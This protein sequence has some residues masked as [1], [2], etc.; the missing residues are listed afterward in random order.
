MD[1]N[2]VGHNSIRNRLAHL[3]AICKM[4]HSILFSGQRGIGKATLAS[5]LA[6]RMFCSAPDTTAADIVPC[7]NCKSCKLIAA[8]NFP[9]IHYRDC[10]GL[11]VE[12]LRQL[13]QILNL[14]AFLGSHKVVILDNADEL[15]LQC[16]N[17]LLEPLEEALAD[18]FFF[19]ITANSGA[20]PIT[21]RS[22]CQTFFFQGLAA[23]DLEI[24]VQRLKGRALTQSEKD[25][26]SLADGSVAGLDRLEALSELFTKFDAKLKSI[27]SGNIPAALE[28]AKE[29]GKQKEQSADIFHVI[30]SLLRAGVQAGNRRMATALLETLRAEESH[31]RRHVN[32]T[33]LFE[34]LF[35]ELA[36]QPAF[37]GDFN[38]ES[39]L[40]QIL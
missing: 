14:K 26:L 35:V 3:L 9:D 10:H 29:L 34:V 24:L 38:E 40:A 5:T 17:V 30:K 27:S 18:T 2:L 1:S 32:L 21:I 28:L 37:T 16:S 12:D 22:R 11:A 4:P 13:L 7:A 25:Q 15:S 31:N 8:K 6:A 33:Y 19:L 23:G 39:H 20:L 36:T